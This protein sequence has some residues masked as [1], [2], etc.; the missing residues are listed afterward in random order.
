MSYSKNGT[1]KF[2]QATSWHHKLFHFH[3]SFESE[4]CGKEGEKIQTSKYLENEKRFLDEIK[5]IFHSF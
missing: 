4:K 2:M 3:L 1:C 5:N